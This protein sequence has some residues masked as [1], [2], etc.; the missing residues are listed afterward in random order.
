MRKKRWFAT[1][2]LQYDLLDDGS[3]YSVS[4]GTATGAIVHIPSVHN[5]K[6]VSAIGE[7]A[8]QDYTA[9]T[10]I[11][12]PDSVASIGEGAFLFCDNLSS[13]VIPNGVTSIGQGAFYYCSS[14]STIT[15]GSGNTVYKSEGKLFDTEKR[16]C[17][18]T[19]L[20]D[21]RNTLI[22]NEYRACRVRGLQ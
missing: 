5:G 13:I 16:Q 15:V 21:K 17:V 22:H 20:Q 4:K 11:T 2:G 14:L 3:G 12:I 18:D 19:W 1:E 7:R 6:V 8:F 10:G 9:L